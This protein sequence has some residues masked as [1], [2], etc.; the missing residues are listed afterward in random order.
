M[1]TEKPE[2]PLSGGLR[3]YFDGNIRKISTSDGSLLSYPTL[4]NNSSLHKFVTYL[5]GDKI[6]NVS[7]KDTRVLEILVLVVA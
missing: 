2:V 4:R 1:S 3:R 5:L 7:S 6:Y